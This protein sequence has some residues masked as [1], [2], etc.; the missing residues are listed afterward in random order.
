MRTRQVLPKI[1]KIS[2]LASLPSAQAMETSNPPR[3]FKPRTDPWL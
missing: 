1:D 2:A 3:A